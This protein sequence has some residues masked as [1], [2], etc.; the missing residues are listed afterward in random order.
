MSHQNLNQNQI[1]AKAIRAEHEFKKSL[2]K[3][4]SKVGHNALSIIGA[5]FVLFIVGCMLYNNSKSTTP[6]VTAAPIPVQP[7]PV[8]EQV[9]TPVPAVEA[10]KVKS[11][12]PSPAREKS[13]K[14]DEV[15][16]AMEEFKA[17]NT[18]QQQ[19]AVTEA[20]PAVIL[21]PTEDLQ[22]GGFVGSLDDLEKNLKSEPTPIDMQTKQSYEA[23]LDAC[24]T[25]DKYCGPNTNSHNAPKEAV[26]GSR[27]PDFLNSNSVK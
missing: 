14:Q 23:T 10:A 3:P 26:G 6:V 11:V 12:N 21:K 27:T 16:Q 17:R 9:E 18:V 7:A 8:V 15:K 4:E 19:S 5:I 22:G 2:P 1:N 25:G 24:I 20:T 13:S